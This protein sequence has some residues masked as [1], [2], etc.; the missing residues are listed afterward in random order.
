MVAQLGIWLVDDDGLVAQLAAAQLDFIGK[1]GE[2]PV[3][4]GVPAVERML[5]APGTRHPDSQK[6]L[7][8]VLHAI[9]RGRL[10]S[11]ECS[12]PH[13]TGAAPCHQQIMHKPVPGLIRVHG[14]PDPLVVELR[15]PLARAVVTQFAR[16]DPQQVGQAQRA[17]VDKLRSLQKHVDDASTSIRGGIGVK[18]C[19][20]LDRG[21]SSQSVQGDTA[22]EFGVCA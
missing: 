3:V 12:R 11:I 17:E 1:G 2:I 20:L 21:Q 7:P 22:Q 18:G 5:V 19:H 13:L 15:T 8:D 10:D 4:V 14:V 9:V 6:R 16:I